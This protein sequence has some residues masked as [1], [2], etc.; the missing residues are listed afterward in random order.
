MPRRRAACLLFTLSL[1]PGSS[2]AQDTV[3]RLAETVTILAAPD[4]LA[5]SLRVEVTAPTARDAQ[6]RVNEMMRDAVANAR[7]VEGVS[8]SNGGYAVWRVSTTAQDRGAQ[9]RGAQDRGAQDRGEKWQAGETLNLS[10]R[11]GEALLK[12]MG[13][14]QQKGLALSD[15]RWRLSR[16]L[17]KK[18]RAE[19]TKQALAALRG[20]ADEAAAALDLRFEAYREVRLD[21]TAAATA[22]AMASMQ[23]GAV[24]GVGTRDASP[25]SAETETLPVVTT[26]EADALLRPRGGA[27]PR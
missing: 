25:P 9:D 10:G 22:A 16:D 24:R 11:D 26:V 14:L 27:T 8:V 1:I 3:L 23:R 15:L 21:N 18:T 20:R 6:R 19:A 2:W 5:A 17:E 4:E 13:E 7:K 12:L